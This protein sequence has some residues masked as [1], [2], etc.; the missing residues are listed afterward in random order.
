MKILAVTCYTGN[1][2]LRDMTEEML[3]G[4]SLSKPG[5][6]D[7]RT[8]VVGQGTKHLIRVEEPWPV[9]V[10]YAPKNIGFAFG[11]NKAIDVVQT[12][13]PDYVL[14]LNNDLQFP[15]KNWLKEL[16]DVSDMDHICVPAT[17]KAAIRIQ[18]GPMDLNP[19]HVPEMSAYCW[20]VPFA[21]CKWLKG[22]YGYWLFDEDFLSYGEDNW[23]AFLLSKKYGQNIFRYVRRSWVKHLRGRTSAYVKPDRKKS[24]NALVDKL[25]LHLLDTR[26]RKDLRQ[27][28]NRYIK[29]LTPRC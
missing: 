29:I 17:D 27:W 10:Q 9:T 20:L 23:A 11:M 13:Q 7:L 16:V 24:N 26:L 19:I 21:W 12:W 2:P 22:Q 1:E 8:S 3:T 25:K 28:A 18:G 5:I 14:C 4:L 6:A 15:H